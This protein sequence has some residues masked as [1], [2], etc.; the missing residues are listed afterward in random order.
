[1][2]KIKCP[3]C[4]ELNESKAKFCM[5]CATKLEGLP[6][7]TEK[8]EPVDDEAIQPANETT[9]QT[10]AS[11][12]PGAEPTPGP[13][14]EPEA[15]KDL[16]ASVS[17]DGN[18]AKKPAKKFKKRYI[19]IGALAIILLIALFSI[20]SSPAV[21][22]IDV[23][24]DGDTSAGVVLDSNNDGIIVKGYDKDGN[25]YDISDWTIDKPQ[26]LEM[27][28]T[29]TVTVAYKDLTQDLTVECSTSELVEI[30]ASYSGDAEEGV[31][32]DSENEG[33]T[34][35]AYYKNGTEETVDGWTIE[36]PQTL[37]ANGTADVV[38][39]YEDQEYTL[40]VMCTTVTIDKIKAKY[41][42][43]TKAGVTIDADSSD[44]TVTAVYKN[45]E[46]EKVTGWTVEEPVT[47]KEGKTSKLKIHYGE[48]DCVL[49]IEC[50]DLS[51]GQY[52][53]KCKSYSYDEIARDPDD[54]KGKKAKFSGEVLQV[55]ESSDSS[56]VDIRLAINDDYDQ[57]IYV[58]YDMPEGA[59]RILEDDHITVYGEL[60]GVYTY[61]S[62]MNAQITIPIIYAAFID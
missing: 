38:I 9:D 59:S 39:K 30:S 55:L 58:V 35:T 41:S 47:L 43:S 56:Q 57:V 48:Y 10:D 17:S 49:K 13:A 40:N 25:E 19:G 1:M 23:S 61:T 15:D 46:K 16:Q 34:V 31:V 20:F 62:T 26:T 44:V 27:D 12:A 14:P 52:K 42:G 45:G 11:P 53:E 3:N 5:N 24:Y 6:K 33:F 60:D 51:K 2:D 32:L 29:S 36:E 37:E 18:G 54:Y 21:E 8:A 28:G 50:T 7:G 22:S 4:G